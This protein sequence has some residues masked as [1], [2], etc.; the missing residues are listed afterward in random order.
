MKITRTVL[1]AALTVGAINLAS[2]A[3]DKP[4]E[5][6]K[7][8]APASQPAAPVDYKKLKE[9]LP[10]TLGGIKRTEASG[11]RTGFGEFK[12]STAQGTYVKDKEKD[13]SPSIDLQIQDFGGNKQMIEGMSY[14]TKLEIDK[15]GDDG[16]HKTLKIQDQ[17]AMQE[18]RNEGKSGTLTLLVGERFFVTVNV[19][20]MTA[21]EFKK[22]GDELKL[23]ELAALK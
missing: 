15:E 13:D 17:P 20:N 6:N 19:Q 10:E 23:K 4:A 2:F 9:H 8:K 1:V 16:F 7:D 12:L 21:D 11:E 18:Y 14:W 5:E 22:L 3:Q